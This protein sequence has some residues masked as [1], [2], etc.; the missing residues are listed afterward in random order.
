MNNPIL[1]SDRHSWKGTSVCVKCGCK[2]HSAYGQLWY[3]RTGHFM[4]KSPQCIDW[5]VEDKKTID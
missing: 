1:S 4:E 3:T 5:E 2:K